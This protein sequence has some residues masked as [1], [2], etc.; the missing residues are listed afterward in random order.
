[1]KAAMVVGMLLRLCVGAVLALSVSAQARTPAEA[2]QKTTPSATTASSS[3]SA[4]SPASPA[5]AAPTT[6][7]AAPVITTRIVVPTPTRAGKLLTAAQAPL[8]A[9]LTKAFGPRVV[10]AASVVAAQTSLGIT[11]ATLKTQP[12]GVD[13]S[14]PLAPAALTRLGEAV[15]AERAVMVEVGD[16]A[17]VV[18]VYQALDG[19]ALVVNVPR[20]KAAALDAA[21]AQAIAVELQRV[22]KNALAPDVVA[23]ANPQAERDVRAEIV[24]EESKDRSRAQQLERQRA[25]LTYGEPFAWVLVGG[26]VSQRFFDVTGSGAGAL[27]R[28]VYG[29]VPGVS[30]Y[31]ALSPLRALPSWR[32]SRWLD[33]SIEAAYRRGFPSVSG[34][35]GKACNVDDDDAFVRLGYRALPYD[36]AWVPRVGIT[37]T[38]EYERVQFGCD[39]AVVSTAFSSVGAGARI[40]QP[41]LPR[42][43]DNT[44]SILELDLQ[45]GVRAVLLA[46]TQGSVAP[47]LVAEGALVLRPWQSDVV[48]VALRAGP[49][50]TTASADLKNAS[51]E[52]V[53][54]VDDKRLSFDL[55]LGVVF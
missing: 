43:D 27:S 42:S 13:S 24:A 9:E 49:R 41:L 34:A 12:A 35:S 40:T 45:G 33:V 51:G 55:Q 19:T 7:L 54:R 53:L 5:A 30:V 20:K 4:A 31:A 3:A 47:G 46:S 17:S 1:M 2:A 11:A 21:W 16:K 14:G 44:G 26:G 48:G 52:S 36:H 18:L 15:A 23:A 38:L 50:F 32:A 37:A 25:Q 39:I 10:D 8:I 22:A 28:V 6:E 29:R